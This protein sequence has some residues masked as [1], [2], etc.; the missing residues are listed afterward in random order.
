MNQWRSA[1]EGHLRGARDRGEVTAPIQDEYIVNQL[2]SMLLGAQILAVM[3]PG[4]HLPAQLRAQ[5][6][7]Y[8]L[9]LSP[10]TQAT[11][12]CAETLFANRRK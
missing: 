9:L 3:S 6:D 5:L 11:Q 2:M 10:T 12:P 8:L 7:A 4:K 1:L